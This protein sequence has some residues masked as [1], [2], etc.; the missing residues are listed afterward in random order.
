MLSETAR[1]AYPSSRERAASRGLTGALHTRV[2]GGREVTKELRDL[3]VS[4]KVAREARSAL[5]GRPGHPTRCWN[6]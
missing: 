2:I 1:G 3:M 5:Q 4:L 6:R